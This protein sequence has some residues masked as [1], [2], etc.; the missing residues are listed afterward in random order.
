VATKDNEVRTRFTSPGAPEAAEQIRNVGRATQSAGDRAYRAG[1]KSEAGFGMMSRSIRGIAGMIGI[2]TVA[3]GVKDLAEAGMNLQ[4]QQ[5]ALRG[6]LKATGIT[7]AAA[8]QNIDQAAIKSSETGGFARDEE[9]QSMTQFVQST[10]SSTDAIRANQAAVD[11]ARR[12]HMSFTSAQK[13]LGQALVGNVNRLR[14]YTG[15]TEPVK[16][17]L[18]NLGRAHAANILQW[19]QEEK[20]MGAAGPAWLRQQEF[21]HNITEQMKQHA[22]EQDR[23]ATGMKEVNTI[24]GQG[25]F[26]KAQKQFANTTAGKATDL[27]QTFQEVE[28]AIG[29]DLLPAF[30]RLLA[31]GQKVTEWI[32]K[33]KWAAVALSIVVTTM[34]AVAFGRMLWHGLVVTIEPFSKLYK[35]V[36]AHTW[37]AKADADATKGEAVANEEQ[38]VA[39]GKAVKATETLTA[40][41]KVKAAAMGEDAAAT[42]TA[43]V[44]TGELATTEV[45]TTES[46]GLLAGAVG[47]LGAAF[48]FLSGNWIVIALAAIGIGIYELITHF[49]DVSKWVSNAFHNIKDAATDAKNFLKREF[50]KLV[51][52]LEWPFIKAWDFIKGVFNKIK[53]EAGKVGHFIMHDT[54][55][56]TVA[57][58]GSD[59]LHFAENLYTGG[60]VKSHPHAR[61]LASG[62]T[63][64][65][66]GTDT[67]E[68]WLSPGEG[69]LNRAAMQRIGEQ[70][71]YQLNTGTAG[72]GGAQN[73]TITPGA[74]YVQ[75]DGRTIARAVVQY[76]LQKAARGPSGLVGGSLL[77]GVRGS[78][79]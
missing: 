45:V 61:Y 57:H 33:N 20:T 42:E 3:F 67:E 13:Y 40:A 43:T 46:T 58:V 72:F 31:V 17:A 47:L 25:G 9:I 77:T 78:S 65:P 56:G 59:I 68:T 41:E 63:P 28:A 7:G 4:S 60:P 14:Q 11:L 70:G 27:R 38:A 23:V 15:V 74:V 48:D 75:L 6:A 12:E 29:K 32:D 10:H 49:K 64:G 79:V 22:D 26:A 2:S 54:P 30:D 18:Y 71:L 39:S 1:R 36:R 73:I 66:V 62:G 69:V 55:V 5:T 35:W 16:T 37:A 50:D 24:L 52:I 34:M 19:E 76:T 44:A 51:G 53:N 8:Y 21:E